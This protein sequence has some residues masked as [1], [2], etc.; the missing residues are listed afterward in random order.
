MATGEAELLPIIAILVGSTRNEYLF[1]KKSIQKRVD[2][3][4]EPPRINLCGVPPDENGKEM[5]TGNAID[6]L[7]YGYCT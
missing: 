2:F 3:L 1:C 4:A 5:W 7:Y 6:N